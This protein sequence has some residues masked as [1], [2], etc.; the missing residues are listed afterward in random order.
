MKIGPAIRKLREER[1]LTLDELAFDA[2]TTKSSLSRIENGTQTP[3]LGLLCAISSELGVKVYQVMALAEEI[4]LPVATTTFA[5]N[6]L[7]T[8][9]RAMEPE[10]RYHIE[11]I[12]TALAPEK[13]GDVGL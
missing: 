2:N 7:L 5:E 6:E 11:A 8:H 12:A 3:S 9:Y 13:K 4:E 10:S 1:K